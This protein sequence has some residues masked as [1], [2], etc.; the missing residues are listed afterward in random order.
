MFPG[1]FPA[2][3]FWGSGVGLSAPGGSAS[4]SSCWQFVG[5]T[6]PGGRGQEGIPHFLLR[7]GASW[8]PARRET[9]QKNASFSCG[10]GVVPPCP[11]SRSLYRQC[12]HFLHG[13]M[14]RYQLV[15]WN[16]SPQAQAPWLRVLAST[17]SLLGHRCPASPRPPS[18]PTQTP[19]PGSVLPL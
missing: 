7:Q 11:T 6:R 18:S 12:P 5:R 16:P 10:S 13:V 14:A 8:S 1:L 19:G 17:A 9:A 15:S 4:W 2:A 3:C